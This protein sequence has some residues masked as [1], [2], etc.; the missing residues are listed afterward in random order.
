[1]LLNTHSRKHWVALYGRAGT[2]WLSYELEP[3]WVEALHACIRPSSRVLEVGAGSGRVTQLLTD[4]TESVVA[5]DILEP[6]AI[7]FAGA[8]TYIKADA[9]RLPFKDESFDVLVASDVL[10]ILPQPG[11]ALAEWRR[12]LTF[13]GL[14]LV[15]VQSLL[16]DTIDHDSGLDVGHALRF[17]PGPFWVD[18]YSDVDLGA[19]LSSA[20]LVADSVTGYFREDPPHEHYPRPHRHHYW[21]ARAKRVA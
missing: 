1:M 11:R 19:L 2:N 17:K 4:L 20:G 15:N 12:V 8:A 13:S 18:Y 3:E 21:F 6:T 14:L 9:L 5:T 7:H 16:D 10:S